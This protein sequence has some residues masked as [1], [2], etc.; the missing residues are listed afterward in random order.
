MLPGPISV[1]VTWSR[2]IDRVGMDLS[3]TSPVYD[4]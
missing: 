3:L 1:L 2:D 4:W